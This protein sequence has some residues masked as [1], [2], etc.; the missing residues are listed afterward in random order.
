MTSASANYTTEIRVTISLQNI[1]EVGH[2]VKIGTTPEMT[3]WPSDRRAQLQALVSDKVI[4]LSVAL[5][6]P[7]SIPIAY[8]HPPPLPESEAVSEEGESCSSPRRRP[9]TCINLKDCLPLMTL[10]Q[11]PRPLP[12]DVV[13]FLRRS[14]CGF[15]GR[16]P[17][18]CCELSSRPTITTE[19]PVVLSEKLSEPPKDVT[20]DFRLSFLPRRICGKR[21]TANR[22]IG[23]NKT[24]INEYPWMALVG[25]STSTGTVFRCGASVISSRYVLTAAHCLINLPQSL[26]LSTVRLGEHDLS[27]AVD[28][29]TDPEL[30]TVISC[31]PPP[32]D[33]AIERALPHP[34]FDRKKLANDIG[35]I[36]LSRA[37]DISTEFIR[38]ICL[39]VG[40]TQG[41]SMEGKKLKVAGWGATESGTSS[42]DLLQTNVPVVPLS[43]CA[44]IYQAA[45]PITVRQLCAGG[46]VG[47]SCSGDSGGPL[48]QLGDVDD[49]T[50]FVQFGIV[51]FGPK[52]CGTPDKPGVYTRVGYYMDWILDNLHP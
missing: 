51:S 5:V 47:D 1:D 26:K 31:A 22:I 18:V 36:R 41:L 16:N 34:Q 52:R 35:L 28:C 27:V 2:G 45:V 8:L 38:P 10:L 7:G 11:Q 3:T 20:G 6:Q 14:Q 33:Y 4:S 24:A 17:L 40:E 43:R 25:Y 49:E 21:D 42:D 32:Q 29:E 30:G 23:G 13:D 39:P 44:S 37:A 9:G 48:F 12:P 46:K 19:S 15:V 50:R